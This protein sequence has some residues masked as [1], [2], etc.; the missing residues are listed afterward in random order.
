V[1]PP[2]EFGAILRHAF[3]LARCAHAPS[4]PPGECL[5]DDCP[6]F[7]HALIRFGCCGGIAEKIN[8]LS[9]PATVLGGRHRSVNVLS[10]SAFCA[11]GCSRFST[12]GN[13]QVP[14][15]AW[16]VQGRESPARPAGL[17]FGQA[18]VRAP[19]QNRDGE[20]RYRTATPPA[21]NRRWPGSPPLYRASVTHGY[22]VSL[23]SWTSR[24][25]GVPFRPESGHAPIRCAA[26]T[27]G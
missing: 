4:P 14:R 25:R 22:E 24:S 19:A 10:R 8:R 3:P 1:T 21:P 17:P 7:V 18:A 13:G 11:W 20:G 15:Y 26:L 9:V 12:C 5:V 6:Y 2:L 16:L 23:K 27:A